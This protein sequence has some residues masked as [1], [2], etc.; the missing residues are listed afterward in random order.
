MLIDDVITDCYLCPDGKVCIDLA[1]D[2]YIT[3]CVPYNMG[4]LYADAGNAD[5]VRYADLSLFTGEPLPEPTTCPTF[6]GFP[7]CG[8]NCGGCPPETVCT[9]RSPRHPYR[10]CAPNNSC[11]PSKEIWCGAG[12]GCF[13][14]TVE[15][16]AQELANE[17][18]YC[19]PLA[20]C[21]A[22]AAELPGGGSCHVP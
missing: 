1:H 20:T 8:G 18:G 13:V 15:P 19:Y 21:Q 10:I 9:G 7:I 17:S 2:Q 11:A 6:D 3:N 12:Q 14:W 22:M 4:K 16:E 5:S